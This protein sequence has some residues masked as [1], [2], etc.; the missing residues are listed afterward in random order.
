VDKLNCSINKAKK[1]LNWRPINSKIDKIIKDEII[2]VKKLIKDKK[3]RKF[4]NYL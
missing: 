2:F 1:I 4:K 3:Y